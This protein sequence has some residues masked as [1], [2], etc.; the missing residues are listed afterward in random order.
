MNI[1]EPI[2]EFEVLETQEPLLTT[3]VEEEIPKELEYDEEE[4]EFEE[5]FLEEEEEVTKP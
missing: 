3:P 1:G 5:E 4:E 2:R